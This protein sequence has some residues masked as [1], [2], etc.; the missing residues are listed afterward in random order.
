MNVRALF[1]VT[2]LAL[3]GATATYAAD[4]ADAAVG[5]W[6]LNVSKSKFNPGPGPKSL[7]RVYKETADGMSLTVTG[8]SG[9]GSPVS[10]QST[11]KYD[12]KDYAYT[13]APGWDM[14]ALKR[15]NGTTVKSTLKKGGKVVGTSTR[16]ISEH[17]KVMTLTS[18]STDSKGV[19]H[20][21]V[22]VYEKK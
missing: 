1:A 21:D 9:D 20:E 6:E 11:F 2:V 10:M 16:S 4:K 15:V 13:G 3:A 17:G 7:T 14:I 22:Q 12:G 19:Q 8:T 18:K 5:T